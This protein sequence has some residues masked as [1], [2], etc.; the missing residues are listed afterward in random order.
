M[1]KNL[2]LNP[3]QK[4]EGQHSSFEL[5]PAIGLE[6]E[7]VLYI[8][9]Q[10]A[11]PEDWF[12][13]PRSFVRSP[14]M[15]REGTSYHLP[16]GVAV[17]F[18]S[19]VLELATPLIEIEPGCAARAGR[20]L[21]EAIQYIRKELDVWETRTGHTARLEGFSTHYNVSIDEEVIDTSAGRTVPQL[22]R[23]LTEILPL[24]VMLLGTNKRSTGVGV[25][26]RPMRIEITADFAP[27][28]SLM[29]AT[30]TLITGVVR[31]VMTW[32]IWEMAVLTER[33][34]PKLQDFNPKKHTSRKGWLA[35]IDCFPASP[36]A[37]DPNEARWYIEGK[38]MPY[39]LRSIAIWI[40]RYFRTAIR[41]LCDPFTLRLINSILLGRMPSLL[42][43][44]DRPASYSHV[45]RITVWDDVMPAS[46]LGQSRYERVL[47]RAIAG[48]T[49]QLEGRMWTPTRMIGWAQVEL[50]NESLG[51]SRRESLEFLATH[52]D[53][54]AIL[55]EQPLAL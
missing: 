44:G 39:S 27:S 26:P 9:E 47:V 21:W 16:S 38:E 11:K 50:H 32:N 34:L 22:A 54:W 43:L 8:D 13:D 37:A 20:L 7:F 36:F 40:T 2:E 41:R 33:G 14:L 30:A 18:D 53:A 3:W 46:I 4:R 48:H 45:G 17:Y 10:P 28:P 42:D 19:G 29:I 49:L 31:E 51:V 35:H 25:R 12:T 1:K 6:A 23:F 52:L 15:H 5:Q 55:K 24:P